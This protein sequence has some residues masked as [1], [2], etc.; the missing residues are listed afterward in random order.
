[1]AEVTPKYL[2]AME[3]AGKLAAAIKSKNELQDE[4]KGLRIE[5]DIME[6]RIPD[7]KKRIEEIQKEYDAAVQEAK[8]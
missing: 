6:S 8:S 5:A 3:L 2:H 4:A 7:A 1:M